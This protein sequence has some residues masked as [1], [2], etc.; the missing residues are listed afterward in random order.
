MRINASSIAYS[1]IIALAFM[2]L[3]AVWSQPPV[4][5]A[6]PPAVIELPGQILTAAHSDLEYLKASAWCALETQQVA[7]LKTTGDEMRFRG[8]MA[9]APHWRGVELQKDEQSRLDNC[10]TLRLDQVRG[11][12]DLGGSDRAALTFLF[13]DN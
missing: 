6:E 3:I 4:T 5:P 13:P 7:V 11:N 9:I 10:V 8:S 2:G 12:G 1:W